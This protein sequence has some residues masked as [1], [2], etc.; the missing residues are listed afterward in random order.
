M[1]NKEEKEE[2]K[3]WNFMLFKFYA[4]DKEIEG[5]LP[6]M[7]ISFIFILVFWLLIWYFFK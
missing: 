5:A 1:D 7:V 2:E 4:T 3:L 6:T